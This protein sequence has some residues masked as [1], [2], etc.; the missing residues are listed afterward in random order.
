MDSRQTATS[1]SSKKIRSVRGGPA[2]DAWG[3]RRPE[4]KWWRAKRDRT[5]DRPSSVVGGP[6]RRGWA[7]SGAP[8]FFGGPSGVEHFAHLARQRTLGERLLEERGAL[9]EDAVAV[10]GLV[11]VAGH[12]QDPH[13]GREH[14][15]ASRYGESVQRSFLLARKRSVGLSTFVAVTYFASFAV[16]GVGLW[17]GLNLMLALFVLPESRPGRRDVKFDF[18]A[19]NPL[20]PLSWAF[21]LAGL[22]PLIAIFFVFNLTG[23]VYGTAWALWGMDVFDWNGLMVGLSLGAFG[24][25]K[26]GKCHDGIFLD[27]LAQHVLLTELHLRLGEAHVGQSAVL[28]RGGGVILP[29]FGAFRRIHVGH[30]AAAHDQGEGKGGENVDLDH[31]STA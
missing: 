5:G 27:A 24:L 8:G 11:G 16:I 29:L 9:V 30:G 6:R 25:F 4:R 26:Q 17:V 10:D 1:T 3:R 23:Q 22:L 13:V 12:E 14:G 18:A 21:G 28:G 19:L 7:A 2:V 31:C 15:E 20:K